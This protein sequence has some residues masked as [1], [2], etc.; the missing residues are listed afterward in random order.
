VFRAA[1]YGLIRAFVP[2]NTLDTILFVIGYNPL[3]YH[4]LRYAASRAGKR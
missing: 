3:R 1:P 2:R 4:A